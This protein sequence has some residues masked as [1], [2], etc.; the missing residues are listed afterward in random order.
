MAKTVRV[1]GLR[2]LDR[3]LG[4]LPK[5]TAKN[6]L[7]RVALARLEPMA[8]EM[9]RRVPVDAG[10]LKKGITVTTKNPRRN[11]KKS[12]V[13][14]HAGPG[15]HPQAHLREFGGDKNPPAPYV[16]PAWDGGKDELLNGVGADLWAEIQ[17]AAQR[18][19]KKAARLAAKG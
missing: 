9:R 11:R 8:E 1:E 14:A 5:A 17:K 2:E 10:D 7:R 19:A 13:E 3:A 16:R 4:Q 15:R 12:T 6:V 18:A